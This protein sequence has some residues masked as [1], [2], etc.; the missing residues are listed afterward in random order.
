MSA[1][2]AQHFLTNRHAVERIIAAVGVEP[3]SQILEIG[4]G[5][6]VLTAFLQNAGRLVVVEIDS[7]MVERLRARF[8]SAP[9]LTIVEDDILSFD[10]A[11]LLDQGWTVVGNL[12]YNLTSPI[13]RKLSVWPGWAQAI[14]MVQKE[15][16]DRLVAA[17]GEEAYGALTVGVNLT[18]TVAK[19]FD[20]SPT[21]F[22]PPPKVWSSVLRLCRREKPLTDDIDGTQKV[23]QAAFQQRRKTILNSL[24]HGLGKTREQIAEL[25]AACQVDPTERPE[26][27]SVETFVRLGKNAARK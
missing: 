9:H 24:S 6:G 8:P 21:S 14:L 4:P 11:T 1:R 16:G 19:V 5:K 17:P 3:T 12:P 23:I 18:S 25:L 10:L 26:R 20:L 13:L 7:R 22:D 15:V 2:F 27:L